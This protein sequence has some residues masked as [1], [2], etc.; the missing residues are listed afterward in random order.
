M[1]VFR[2]LVF[3]VL[4]CYLVNLFVQS[5]SENQLSRNPYHEKHNRPLKWQNFDNLNDEQINPFLRPLG[6]TL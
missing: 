3:C 2:V 6:R 1:L 5:F 4:V